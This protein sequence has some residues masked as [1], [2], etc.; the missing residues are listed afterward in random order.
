[1]HVRNPVT[2]L[3]ANTET[4]RFCIFHT[5]YTEPERITRI[6]GLSMRGGSLRRMNGSFHISQVLAKEAIQV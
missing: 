6:N 1:M 2:F 5:D 4:T 3:K